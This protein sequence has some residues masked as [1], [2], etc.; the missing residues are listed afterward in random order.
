MDRLTSHFGISPDLVKDLVLANRIL[1]HHKVLDTF[2][3]VSVR[4]HIQYNGIDED[5][6]L[7]ATY[8][9][10]S[11]VHAQDIAIFSVRT[12]EPVDPEEKRKG[13]LERHIHAGLYRAR[14]EV[15]A[16]LHCHAPM[17]VTYSILPNMQS[18]TTLQPVL[19]V[20][21]S[22]GRHVPIYEIS[23]HFGHE[24]DLLIKSAELGDDL[25]KL[26][27][28][29]TRMVLMRGHGATIASKSNVRDLVHKGIYAVVN[30][31]IMRDATLLG[32]A[33]GSTNILRP[34]SDGE[35]EACGDWVSA[36]YRS[37]PAWVAELDVKEDD[38][39]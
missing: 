15:Q 18:H 8:H 35:V 24:T 9:A 37:W 32:N 1:A 21:S 29:D 27:S 13:A 11:L 23:D 39:I 25:A 7:Q 17:L 30:A 38:V 2:G 31:T 3:H 26:F 10:P 22:I 28:P 5:C 19:H 16:V 33:T 12:G 6:Y 34:L 36:V 14:P 4:C 20:G